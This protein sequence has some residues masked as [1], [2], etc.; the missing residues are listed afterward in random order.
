MPP[1]Q[2]RNFSDVVSRYKSDLATQRSDLDRA[3]S[4]AAR[5]DLLAGGGGGRAAVDS[6]TQDRAVRATT[7]AKKCVRGGVASGG[8][9]VMA[10]AVDG[11]AVWIPD[12]PV[13]HF[14]GVADC[15]VVAVTTLPCVV[16]WRN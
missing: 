4:A 1:T 8:A 9:A 15:N 5:E 16:D 13:H 6:L 2:R 7:E 3:V 10:R 14:F 12:F 11:V